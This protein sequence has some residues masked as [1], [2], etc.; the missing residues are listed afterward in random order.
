MNKAC[1][2]PSVRLPFDKPVLMVR[3]AHHDRFFPNVLSEV[4]GQAQDERN[5]ESKRSGR[6]VEGRSV[7]AV[8]LFQGQEKKDASR[9]KREPSRD[10]RISALILTIAWVG[11]TSLGQTCTH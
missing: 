3:Q 6:T 11:G 5:R 7:A 8:S 4:E 1:P 2:E 10:F 9:E